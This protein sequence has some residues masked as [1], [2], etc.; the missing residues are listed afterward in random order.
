MNLT[1]EN[2]R[3]HFT[4]ITFNIQEKIRYTSA[5]GTKSV[6]ENFAYLP[7]TISDVDEMGNIVYSQWNY[8]ILCHPLR[9]HVPLN[10]FVSMFVG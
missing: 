6:N 3:E 4:Y 9:Q 2:H 5:T 10:R 1:I 7:T 8:K